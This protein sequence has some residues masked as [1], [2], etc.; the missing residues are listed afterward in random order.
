MRSS[1]AVHCTVKLEK[2]SQQ[3]GTALI[4]AVSGHITVYVRTPESSPRCLI[5]SR[6]IFICTQN[7]D[8]YLEISSDL[9]IQWFLSGPWIRPM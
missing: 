4:M 6:S 1:R 5:Q 3:Y 9:Q 8:F 7:V 2:N